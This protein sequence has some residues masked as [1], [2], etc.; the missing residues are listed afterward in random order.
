MSPE[1]IGQT[2]CMDCRGTGKKD[3]ETTCLT[4]QGTGLV[5]VFGKPTTPTQ[6][7]RTGSPR[8]RFSRYYTDL[9]IKIR[10][11]REQELTGRCVIIAEGGLAAIL[12]QP[13]STGSV[14][15]LRLSI[16]TH[17]TVLEVRVVV[18][19]QI[20]LR[21]GFEF[22]SLTDSERMAIRQFCAG[23]MVQLELAVMEDHC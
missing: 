21:H 3:D 20:G 11:Q 19:D 23:L 7:L 1:P 4:C 9:P 8:R 14:A 22:V 18:R 17:P 15:T 5:A 10:D 6:T 2:C 16:P 13:T 12:P